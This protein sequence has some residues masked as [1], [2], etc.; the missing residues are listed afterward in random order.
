MFDQ[1]Y[2]ASEPI[3]WVLHACRTR[4][5][6]EASFAKQLLIVKTH[7]DIVKDTCNLKYDFGEGLQIDELLQI[8]EES[9]LSPRTVVA[10]LVVVKI[11]IRDTYARIVTQ[12]Y[13]QL[14]T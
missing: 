2:W 10:K 8:F 9:T 6:S 1:S 7:I 11:I 14:I 5:T 4:P 3:L 12:S 13:V